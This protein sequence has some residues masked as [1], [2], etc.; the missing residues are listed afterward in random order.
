MKKIIFVLVTLF[1]LSIAFA[2]EE[3]ESKFKIKK[4]NLNIR[5]KIGTFAGNMM[6]STTQELDDAVG[7]PYIISGTYPSEINTSESK[8]FPKGTIE[9]DYLV[10]I[11]FMK[12]EGMGMYKIEGTVTCEGQEL[13]YLGMGSYMAVFVYAINIQNIIKCA[14]K[15][16]NIS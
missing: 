8:L 11:S 6:T 2:Q 5:E 3:K 14:N 12:G 13:E 9:G 15:S 1:S 7:K 10:G 4:P 16:Q